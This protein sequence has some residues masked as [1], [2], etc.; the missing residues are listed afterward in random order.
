M[1]SAPGYL[2]QR[3][4]STWPKRL[5]GTVSLLDRLA[6]F[7]MR[8][9]FPRKILKES[10][11]RLACDVGSVGIIRCHRLPG[12]VLSRHGCRRWRREPLGLVRETDEADQHAHRLRLHVRRGL[13]QLALGDEESPEVVQLNNAVRDRRCLCRRREV[14][15]AARRDR[16]HSACN[17]RTQGCLAVSVRGRHSVYW[18]NTPACRR[19]TNPLVLYRLVQQT[20]GVLSPD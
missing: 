10:H 9:R 2:P 12:A 16:P 4:P 1:V 14:R 20:T 15:C 3:P 6:V 17:T 11:T 13:P 5:G 19:P 7:V 8:K 18:T